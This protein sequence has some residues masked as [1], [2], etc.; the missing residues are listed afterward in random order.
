VTAGWL[1]PD[2]GAV[3]TTIDSPRQVTGR[4]AVWAAISGI[5]GLLANVLLVLFFLLARPFSD[6]QNSFGWLGTANDAVLIVQFLAMI[7]VALALRQWL[8]PTRSVQVA[9]AMGVGAMAAVAVL[10]LLLIRGVLGFD[11][12]VLLVVAAFLL[13]YASIFTVSSIGHRQ[14]ALPRAVT[15]FGLLLGMSYPVGLLIAGAGFLIGTASGHPLVF[16]I[17][18]IVLGAP[19]WLALPVWPLVLAHLVFN[20]PPSFNSNREGFS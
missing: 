2:A 11:V 12:Q 19:G 14:G 17:P 10:Q 7:P 15:R 5:A 6:V 16:A 3:V 13:V 4:P 20:K 8:P 18:G 9:T 1:P